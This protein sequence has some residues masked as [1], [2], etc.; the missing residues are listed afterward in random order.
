MF[1]NCFQEKNFFLLHFIKPSKNTESVRVISITLVLKSRAA[2]KIKPREPALI[3]PQPGQAR[4][5]QG[6]IN[7]KSQFTKP[8]QISNYN[9]QII[10]PVCSPC[11]IPVL[12]F[13]FTFI[14]NA[15]FERSCHDIILNALTGQARDKLR[16]KFTNY[17]LGFKNLK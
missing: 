4:T 2:T 10:K 9:A 3:F 14:I 5:K 7:Y 13:P 6:L 16:Q 11:Y 17:D 8:K 15:A 12:A 1:F